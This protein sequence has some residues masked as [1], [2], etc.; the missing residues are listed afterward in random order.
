MFDNF[1]NDIRS[2]I[3]SLV[4]LVV[5]ALAGFALV[6]VPLTSFAYPFSSGSRANVIGIANATGVSIRVSAVKERENQPNLD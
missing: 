2:K 4:R 1:S 5:V 6:D 3:Y